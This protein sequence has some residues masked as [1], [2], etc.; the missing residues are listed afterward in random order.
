MYDYSLRGKCKELSEEA[1]KNDHS[2]R[3]VRGYYY[4][5]EWGKQP[6]WWTERPDGSVYDPTS[7]QFPSLGLGTYE[8]LGEF[9][10]CSECGK[11]IREED[12]IIGGNGHYIFCSGR[13]YGR[14]VGV[15]VD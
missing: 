7:S 4:C 2:L 12:G 14:C 10:Q 8:E 5:W 6:H 3:L 13:C 11:E 15:Y 9:V 1:V